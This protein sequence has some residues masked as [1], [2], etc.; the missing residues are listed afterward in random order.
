MG[1]KNVPSA[2]EETRKEKEKGGEKEGG[3]EEEGRKEGKKGNYLNF[4]ATSM[5]C[6]IAFFLT[7]KHLEGIV[8]MC[9]LYT[10]PLYF[11]LSTPEAPVAEITTPSLLINPKHS[12]F[13]FLSHCTT[14]LPHPQLLGQL[15]LL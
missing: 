3:K 9:N 5:S 8:H 13:G 4:T 10:C 1:K 14:F 2:K 7:V 12:A 11:F 15:L 6:P